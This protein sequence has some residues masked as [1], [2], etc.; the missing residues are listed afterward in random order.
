MINEA[1]PIIKEYCSFLAIQMGIHSLEIS[2]DDELNAVCR[3]AYELKL[4][5]GNK[6]INIVVFKDDIEIL[7]EGTFCKRLELK[8]RAALS[9][10]KIMSEP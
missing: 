7:H 2:M 9:R 3:D 5:S 8:I 6:K 1:H 4:A 10:L